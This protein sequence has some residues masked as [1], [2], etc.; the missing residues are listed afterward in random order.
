[1][2]QPIPSLTEDPGPIGTDLSADVAS[3]DPISG[4]AL[5]YLDTEG[6]RVTMTAG[7]SRPCD[8]QKGAATR[9]PR[10]RSR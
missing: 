3:P 7:G 8:F 2:F 10:S 6:H 9:S 4:G 1:M 5:R